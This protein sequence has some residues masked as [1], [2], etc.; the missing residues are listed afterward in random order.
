MEIL[1][2]LKIYVKTLKGRENLAKLQSQYKATNN[3]CKAECSQDGEY[4]EGQE[5]IY[6]EVRGELTRLLEEYK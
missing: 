4:Y 6:A 1:E 3:P 5:N 2:T